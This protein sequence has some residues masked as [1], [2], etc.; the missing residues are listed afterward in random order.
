M[1]HDFCLVNY[2]KKSDLWFVINTGSKDENHSM[3]N[4]MVQPPHVHMIVFITSLYILPFKIC[5]NS[6]HVVDFIFGKEAWLKDQ[7]E[8]FDLYNSTYKLEL[9]FRN[10][11]V[12]G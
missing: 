8:A 10:H 6:F 1:Y 12:L 7:T 5:M 11:I 3:F 2:P 9:I 4:C